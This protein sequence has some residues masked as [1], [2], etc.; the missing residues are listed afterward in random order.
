[1][2]LASDPS[3]SPLLNNL[4]TREA[5]SLLHAIQTFAIY[6]SP[7]Q[8]SFHKTLADM[9]ADIRQHVTDLVDL[10]NQL[11]IPIIATA[12]TPDAGSLAYLSL[13]YFLPRLISEKYR[14]IALHESAL[15][16]LQFTTP[17]EIPALLNAHLARHRE[18]LGTLLRS[19]EQVKI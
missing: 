3:I 2:H 12:T 9:A 6:V 15:A 7:D 11:N 1:M 18:H 19:V 14:F 5:G 8:A 17:P 16:S 4:L 13:G 10:L